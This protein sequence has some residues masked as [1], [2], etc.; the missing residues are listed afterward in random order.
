MAKRKIAL[1]E[2]QKKRNEQ[3]LSKLREEQQRLFEDTRKLQQNWKKRRAE[4]RRRQSHPHHSMG[5]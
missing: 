4:H 3:I 5:D 1:T 2:T